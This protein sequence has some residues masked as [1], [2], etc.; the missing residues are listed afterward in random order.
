[1]QNINSITVLGNLTREPELR[2][3]GSTPLLAGSI[4]VNHAA[5]KN[6]EG[7]WESET[8][9]FN[10]VVLGNYAEALARYLQ[11]GMKVAVFGY[12][13]QRRWK[14]KEGSSRSTVEIVAN[15]VEVM[16]M[17]KSSS[18]QPTKAELTQKAEALTD[19][20]PF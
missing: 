3:A 16:V 7:A 13:K 19:D 17:E 8:S 18:K 11:K 20:I 15:N 14:D 12:L 9:F 2:M 6:S 10:F 1:M 4:A 5:K